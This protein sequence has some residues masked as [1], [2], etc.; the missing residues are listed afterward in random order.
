VHWDTKEEFRVKLKGVKN[1]IVWS[2]IDGTV[3]GS[4]LDRFGSSN[5][6]ENNSPPAATLTYNILCWLPDFPELSPSVV[7]NARSAVQ[8]AKQLYNKI[9]MRPV[10]LFGQVYLMTTKQEQ[11]AEGPYF[12]YNYTADG[13]VQD[14]DLYKRL[15]TMHDDFEK[16]AWRANDEEETGVATEAKA[17]G[18]VGG[19]SGKF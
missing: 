5:P 3:A 14:Q 1:E 15:E 4:G 6:E 7:L 2:T 12:N 17:E 11:G 16:K 10:P 8:P 9:K 19:K 13:Y 18:T